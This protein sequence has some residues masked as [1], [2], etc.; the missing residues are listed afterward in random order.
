MGHKGKGGE[1][2]NFSI[3]AIWDRVSFSEES[4]HFHGGTSQTKLV[5]RIHSTFRM[6]FELLEATAERDGGVGG[7]VCSTII[8]T[9]F[10]SI[11]EISI[12]VSSG[13]DF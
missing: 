2:S 13:S 12:L 4:F 1:V 8:S 5:L 3:G 10:E 7:Q 6:G 9:N 11:L